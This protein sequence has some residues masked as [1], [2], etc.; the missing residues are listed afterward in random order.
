M[1]EEFLTDD[2]VKGIRRLLIVDLVFAAVLVLLSIPLVTGSYQLYG[3]I[4][5]TV[6]IVLA[7]AGGLAWRAVRGRAPNARR[8]CLITGA[9]LVVLSVPLMPIWIGLLT[10]VAGIGL[11]VVVLAPERESR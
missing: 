10:V 3:A 8:L 4:V 6:A 11:L 5:I 1:T 9:L 7:V 2:R